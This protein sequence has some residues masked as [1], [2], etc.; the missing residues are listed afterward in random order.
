MVHTYIK[1][2]FNQKGL[3]KNDNVL[4]F[5]CRIHKKGG[6]EHIP[7]SEL[8]RVKENRYSTES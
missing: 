6:E 4:I 1:T 8:S 2:Q 3:L 5:P 7:D